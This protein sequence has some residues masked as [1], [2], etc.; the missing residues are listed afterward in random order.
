MKILG[1]DPGSVAT[2]YGVVERA[3]GGRL[4]HLCNGAVT[5]GRKRP[6]AERLSHIL[7]AVGDIMDEF[8]PDA[9]AVESVFHAKNARSAIMLGH[10][11][12]VALVAAAER[13]IEV[14]EY[15]PST[16][17]QAV[18][19]HGGADKAQ[20]QKMVT[21]LLSA[22]AASADA[23]DALAVAICHSSAAFAPGAS[24]CA[25]GRS[26]RGRGISSERRAWTT[27]AGKAEKELP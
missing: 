21:A 18:T 12:G 14:F 9:L 27:I 11:R 13:G 23:A 22:E 5:P 17:K 7:R 26:R 3:G 25:G 19:G 1:I 15:P 20:V 24:A 6:L 4:V 2:G 16:V 8:S 10:A